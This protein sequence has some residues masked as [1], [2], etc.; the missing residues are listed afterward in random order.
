MA[1]KKYLLEVSARQARTIVQAMDLMARVGMGDIGEVMQYV[2][3]PSHHPRYSDED[4]K[5]RDY[6]RSLLREA[7]KNLLGMW[8][9]YGLTNREVCEAARIAWD[10]KQVV[11]HKLAWDRDPNGGITVDFNEPLRTSLEEEF[12]KIKDAP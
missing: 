7:Q 5:A 1:E 12:P 2:P 6:A 9:H 10:I 11:R 4:I 8:H 3:E